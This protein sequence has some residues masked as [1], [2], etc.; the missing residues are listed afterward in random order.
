MPCPW[1]IKRQLLRSAAVACNNRGYQPS[2]TTIVRPSIKSTDKESL[3]MDS[4]GGIALLATE[5]C[6]PH[7]HERHRAE[8]RKHC[9]GDLGGIHDRFHGDPIGSDRDGGYRSGEV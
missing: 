7:K 9:N 6:H 3:V 4:T 1:P 8:G 5:L 2:G